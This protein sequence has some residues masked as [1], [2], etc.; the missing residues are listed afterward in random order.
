MNKIAK[1]YFVIFFFGVI[2]ITSDIYGGDILSA[3]KKT[4]KEY[5][6][7]KSG[8]NANLVANYTFSIQ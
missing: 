6:I 7:R 1:K 3:I 8:I 5:I 2:L 4:T